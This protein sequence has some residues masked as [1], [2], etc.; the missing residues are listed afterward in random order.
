MIRSDFVSEIFARPDD[1][2]RDYD[3]LR[4]DGWNVRDTSGAPETQQYSKRGLRPQPKE[5][6]QPA[7]E[8]N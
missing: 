4:E 3:A 7:E 2:C 1:L 5:I 8:D 6:A